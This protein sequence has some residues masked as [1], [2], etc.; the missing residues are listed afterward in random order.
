MEDFDKTE[1]ELIK[2]LNELRQEL[3]DVKAFKSEREQVIRALDQRNRD[4]AFLIQ[5]IQ[6]FISTLPAG[7]GISR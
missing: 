7:V 6:A 1:D 4:L 5:A 3:V 2:E